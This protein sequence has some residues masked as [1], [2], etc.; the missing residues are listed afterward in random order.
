[1]SLLRR[2]LVLLAV[3]GLTAGPT[4]AAPTLSLHRPTLQ[5]PRPPM[6]GGPT[7]GRWTLPLVGLAGITIR[8]DTGAIAKKFSSRAQQA[9][10]EYTT[11]VASAGADW[12]QKTLDGEANYEQGVAASIADKR[13]GRGVQKVGPQKYVDNATKLGSQRYGPGVA[14]SEAAYARGVGPHLDM[15]KSL[16]LPKRGPKGSQQN[17]ARAQA[18]A[19]ANR[20]LKVGK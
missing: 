4:L 20:M 2:L 13:F 8:K 18:V 6:P 11:G 14:N 5:A 19:N 15:M 16:D 12:Q 7:R 1:M 17:Q 3:V 9:G 10:P